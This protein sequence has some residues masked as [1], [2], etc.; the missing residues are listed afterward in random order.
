M[1]SSSQ[2]AMSTKRAHIPSPLRP[3]S[4]MSGDVRP[5]RQVGQGTV[6]DD[7]D[8]APRQAIR[9]HGGEAHDPSKLAVIR[10]KH[11]WI[12][13]FPEKGPVDRHRQELRRTTGRND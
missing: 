8:V 12:V 4:P 5:M 3:M 1:T 9:I 7:A 6:R 11:L 10:Q 13:L 2:A